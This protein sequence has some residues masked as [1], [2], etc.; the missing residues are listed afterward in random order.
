MDIREYGGFVKLYRSLVEWEWYKDSAT[1]HLWIHLLLKVSR[2]PARYKGEQIPPGSYITSYKRLSQ[3]IGL[4]VRTIRTSLNHLKSTGEV[5]IKVR[6]K[7]SIIT[8][9]KWALFQ[10]CDSDADKQV[11]KQVDKQPT[12]NRQATDKQPTSLYKQEIKNI[13]NIEVKNNLN[14]EIKNNHGVGGAPP[15]PPQDIAERISARLKV[16]NQELEE[17]NARYDSE[18]QA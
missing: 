16:M 1:L 7:F 6:S 2:E 9:E 3:E 11:D 17:R 13:R 4:S 18:V 10:W 8:I 14:K 12:S 5:T 15:L